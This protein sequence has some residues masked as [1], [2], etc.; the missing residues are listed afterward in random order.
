MSFLKQYLNQDQKYIQTYTHT[1]TYIYIYNKI[2][3]KF[4][5]NETKSIPMQSIA[6]HIIPFKCMQ[7]FVTNIW[8]VR[9]CSPQTASFLFWTKKHYGVFSAMFW[10]GLGPSNYISPK[11]IHMLSF[12][13]KTKENLFSKSKNLTPKFWS[14]DTCK[15]Y[16]VV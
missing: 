4:F 14:Q 12:S 10:G 8:E 7:T 1:H 6:L 15:I 5:V 16:M 13:V 3:H 9:C 11:G 2:D